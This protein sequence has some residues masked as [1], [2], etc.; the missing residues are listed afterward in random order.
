MTEVI[1]SRFIISILHILGRTSPARRDATHCYICRTHVAWSVCLYVVQWAHRWARS[2]CR[3]G[4]WLTWVQGTII[5]WGQ[6]RTNPFAAERGDKSAIRP[7]SYFEHLFHSSNTRLFIFKWKKDVIICLY[8]NIIFLH[9]Q[10][11]SKRD[12][13]DINIL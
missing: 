4:S 11:N 6:D 9:P 12:H 7:F 5:R 13:T 3:F 10:T 2:R 1:F 8:Q